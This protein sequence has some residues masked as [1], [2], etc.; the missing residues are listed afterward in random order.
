MRTSILVSLAAAGLMT[1]AA[2]AVPLEVNGK[3]WFESGRV[4]RSSDTLQY[5]LNGSWLQS[6]GAQF[7]T[8]ADLGEGWEGAFGF[9]AYQV[10]HSL[11]SAQGL[12]NQPKFLAVTM[13]KSYITQASLSYTRDDLAL[14]GDRFGLTFGNF[15]HHYNRDA[16]NFG[17]YLLRGPVYPGILQSGYGDFGTDT[18]RANVLGVRARYAHHG[19]THDL[20]FMNEK[21]L[22]PT[23]D[24][25]LGYIGSYRFLGAFEV[26]VG[27]NFYRLLPS[28]PD[29]MQPGKLPG[30]QY[31]PSLYDT[32]GTGAG[33]DTLFYT[34]QGVKLM[35]MFSVDLKKWLGTGRMSEQDLRLYGEAAVLGVKDYGT[36]YDDIARRMPVMMGF[37]VPTF[38]VLDL[39]SVE[40]EWYGTPYKNDLANIGNPGSIVAE[41]TTL[42]RPI[43]SPAPIAYADSSRDD[44]KW[45]VTAEKT[46]RRHIQLTAQVANDHFRPRPIATGLITSGGGTSAAFTTSRDWYFTFRVGYFF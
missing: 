31:E 42:D 9:G 14:S 15:S 33:G 30:G 36:Y 25:S 38:G 45:S 26:G 27:V 4:M 19:F 21:D 11:A 35:G 6:S 46:L 24:W 18:S 39:L 43:P 16:R 29:L 8:V 28:N 12:K 23:F 44:W 17:S 41:W 7:T 37:N 5:D 3:G 13:Y 22:P 34:H 2:Q 1:A 10:N 32:T 20:L 40:V